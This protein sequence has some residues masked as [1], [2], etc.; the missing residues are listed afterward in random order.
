VTAGSPAARAGLRKGDQLTHIDGVRITTD[1]GGEM[2]GAV[3]AGQT[4]KFKIR[5]GNRTETVTMT[6]EEYPAGARARRLPEIE[7]REMEREVARVR[8]V[9]SRM[10][11]EQARMER[12]V[13]RELAREEAR[14]RA[15]LAEEELEILKQYEMEKTQHLAELEARVNALSTRLNKL[16]TE[17]AT[18]A[19]SQAKTLRYS[20]RLGSV[21]VV[22]RS[23]RPVM[24]SKDP[25]TG[26]LV[27]SGDDLLIRLNEEEK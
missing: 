14:E 24:V 10:A 2:F 26:E 6:A 15:E 5:R 13:V 1:K 27:I 22:V 12:R 21:N 18:K 3:Q 4:V 8:E 17:A 23:A 11:R 16:H 7:L 25:K 19:E 9:Q 20:G